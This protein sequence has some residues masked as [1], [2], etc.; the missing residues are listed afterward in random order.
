M[1]N[2]KMLKW[3][4][5]GI[6][7]LLVAAITFIVVGSYIDHRELFEQEKAEYP[8]PGKLID[9]DDNGS[10]LHIYS[11]GQGEETL[12]FMSGFGTCSPVLDFKALYSQLSDDYRIAVV[13]R[14]GY[15]WS[16]ITSSPRDIDTVLEETRTVLQLSGESPPYVLF[17]H[18]MAGL[19]AIY[20]ANLYPEE[21][22]AI[23]G[24][25]ALIPDYYEKTEEEP[26]ALSPVIT[27]LARTGLM[28][29]QPD[30][31][32]DNFPAIRKGHLTEEEIEIAC[33]LFYR[34]THTKNMAEE[35]SMLQANSRLVSQQD[36][37]GLPFHAFISKEG[38]EEWKNALISYANKTHGKYFILD[39]GH[40]IHLDKPEL[41]AEKSRKLI[42]RAKG[43]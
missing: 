31:C 10:K 22:K 35:A 15:G 3:F 24:L 34:R 43:K 23:V 6:P 20:W 29:S 13:E 2:K 38:E 5:I 25:D 33:T 36:N 1:K 11:E 18:S 32:R 17:V 21:I 27:F 12:V 26:P 14:G 9:I 40:Y 39:A 4:L 28:R 8:A 16:D 42:E 7:L 41:I 37:L 19:E 30:V